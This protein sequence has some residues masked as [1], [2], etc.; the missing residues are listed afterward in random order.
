MILLPTAFS[1]RSRM[2]ASIQY[3]SARNLF[4]CLLMLIFYSFVSAHTCPFRRLRRH[5]PRIRGRLKTGMLSLLFDKREDSFLY[6]SFWC[7]CSYSHYFR[8]FVSAHTYPFRQLTLPLSPT[9]GDS[10][11]TCMLSLLPDKR[12]QLALSMFLFLLFEHKK[13]WPGDSGHLS[14]VICG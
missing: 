8:S 9:S 4:L 12:G 2:T 11:K 10:L 3:R 13:R 1:L 7:F 5:L 14:F 6:E